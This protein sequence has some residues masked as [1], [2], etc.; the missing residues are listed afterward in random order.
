MPCKGLSLPVDPLPED[1][2]LFGLGLLNLDGGG[3]LCHGGL[4][5]LDRPPLPLP[6]LELPDLRYA[7]GAPE[8]GFVWFD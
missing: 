1:D 8:Y 4:P 5:P 2:E 7:P 6:P 3:S